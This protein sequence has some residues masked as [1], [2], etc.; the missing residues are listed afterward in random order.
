M[1]LVVSGSKGFI[2]SHLLA[3]LPEEK[4]SIF[5]IDIEDG[6]DLSRKEALSKVPKFDVF[7][8]LANM[9]YVPESYTNPESFFR[10]NYLTTLNALELCRKNNARLIFL[11]SYIYGTPEYLPVDE[12]HP[13]NP[14]NPYAQSKYLCEILCDGYLRDFGVKTTILRPFNVYG[15]GQKGKLLI[16]EIFQQLID[17]SKTI[18]LKDGFPRRDYINVTDVAKA[19]KLCI[20]NNDKYG[21]YNICSNK[22][23]SV[24]EVTE[25][26]NS[27][28]IKPV[29]F[30]FSESDRIN[31][32]N[33][34]VGS[35]KKFQNDF[36]WSPSIPLDEGIEEITKNYNI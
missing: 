3:N 14:F 29:V 21:T 2:G 31:E 18:N 15:K 32:V 7:V 36:N 30:I 34:T 25:I 4:Y 17:G 10:I 6:I 12:R 16:P 35:Y 20:D 8:H 33:E 1:K 22:S 26:I 11:S 19:I 24:K 23:Y 9:S 5:S 27:K 13:L 28:L